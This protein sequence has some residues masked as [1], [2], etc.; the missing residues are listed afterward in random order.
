MRS[1]QMPDARVSIWPF[2][3]DFL[4]PAIGIVFAG[5]YLE[6]FHEAV[7]MY[8][9]LGA[10]GLLTGYFSP[11]IVL[12]TFLYMAII[13]CGYI[14][15]RRMPRCFYSFL[16]RYRYAIALVL[17]TAFVVSELS[18]S[19]I[20]MWGRQ[21]PGGTT[22]GLLFGMPRAVRSDEFNAATLWNFSQEFNGYAPLSD[23]LR[24]DLTDTRLVYNAASFSL[25][26]VFRPLLWGF[27]FFGSAKGIAF[28]TMGKLFATF[29]SSFECFRVM[30]ND[31]RRSSLLFAILVTFSPMVLWW[32]MWEGLIYGQ[33]L[34]VAL[35]CLLR[36]GG[37]AKSLLYS[38]SLAWLCG[39]YV[40]IVYP[41]WMVPFFYVFAFMGII[42]VVRFIQAKKYHGKRLVIFKVGSTVF[43]LVIAAL[44]VIASLSASMDVITATSQTVY[45]G[46]RFEVG[47]TVGKELF[48]YVNSMLFPV[49]Q[50]GYS[51]ASELSSMFSLFPLGSLLSI[52]I[53]LKFKGRDFVPLL[54]LQAF[55]LL[56]VIVGVPNIIAKISLFSNCP[57]GRVLF[58]IGYL[59]IY[60]L[61]KSVSWLSHVHRDER[62]HCNPLK[63]LCISTLVVIV[64]CAA[65][66]YAIPGYD[67][68]L[69]R[70][71]TTALLFMV[72]VPIAMLFFGSAPARRC[73]DTLLWVS[74]CGVVVPGFCVH[75]L[76]RGI[77]P[78]VESDF[79]Q[80]VSNIV[81]NDQ[82]A[83]WISEGNWTVSNLLTA[84]GASTVCSTNAYPDL[85]IWHELDPA[86]EYS[87]IYNR[88]AHIDLH[89][90][91]GE[92]SFE[93]IA[94][95]LIRVNISL[96]D[97][98]NLGIEYVVSGEDW[99]S[100]PQKAPYVELLGDYSGL[101]IYRLKI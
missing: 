1:I 44:A 46:A 29:F 17:F 65:G 64:L 7:A 75:P 63:L 92:T 71:L 72:V 90:V 47:G 83:R 78:V 22:E 39:C 27:L 23:I 55:L 13:L 96:R 2:L 50:P 88:Y 82:D 10:V 80:N 24:G 15:L 91:D 42:V 52:F 16:F 35:H 25:I 93:Q 101:K 98:K 100:S 33:L 53:V 68:I 12:R 8:F 26:T 36:S 45:P 67:R 9:D 61:V 41:A 14:I 87:E 74:I 79:A 48:Y 11:V 56:F 34:V 40:M 69:F 89:V 3:L 49:A 58:A 62:G 37:R 28:L 54:M 21:L 97:L 31:D 19:S 5:V 99:I 38:V 66:T 81:A 60:L 43:C 76:Q 18:F 84:L 30:S 73:I 85:D 4:L 20:A 59:E 95:D 57:S 94:G 51:N 77:A 86:G 70:C 6:V 32:S